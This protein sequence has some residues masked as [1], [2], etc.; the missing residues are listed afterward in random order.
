MSLLFKCRPNEMCLSTEKKKN[1]TQIAMQNIQF[2]PPKPQ[3]EIKLPNTSSKTQN[4]LYQEV[5]FIHDRF[6]EN[7]FPSWIKVTCYSLLKGKKDSIIALHIQNRLNQ[8]KGEG[9]LTMIYSHDE[10]NDLGSIYSHL[11]DL[12]MQLKVDILAYD[13]SGYGRSSTKSPSKDSLMKDIELVLNLAFKELNIKKEQL[14]FYGVEIGIV[15]SVL[16]CCKV[17][18]KHVYGMVLVSLLLINELVNG[19][20]NCVN[21]PVYIIHG[22]KNQN[23]EPIKSVCEQFK[24]KQSWFPNLMST[25]EITTQK[26]AKLY[27]KMKSFIKQINEMISSSNVNESLWSEFRL[28]TNL[29]FDDE[30]EIDNQKNRKK[31]NGNLFSPS[32]RQTSLIEIQNNPNNLTDSN[33]NDSDL[34]YEGSL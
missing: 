10:C 7:N 25:E 22:K 15:P 26:R 20:F 19:M 5:F 31:T 4:N 23:Y 11:I 2:T 8:A 21:C 28:S 24:N 12:S 3:Y 6:Q 30:E 34:S 14:I 18:Y 13:Y 1:Q 17:A 9:N 29:P 33:D 32:T 27:I 16:I